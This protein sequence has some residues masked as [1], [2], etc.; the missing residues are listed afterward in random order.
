MHIPHNIGIASQIGKYTDAM[1]VSGHARWLYTSGT[2]GLDQDGNLPGDI[3]GQAGLA[4]RNIVCMQESSSKTIAD[5]VKV[6]HYLTQESDIAE[7]VKIRSN[8]LGDARPASILMIIPA[9]V[10]PDFLVE[11]EVIAAQHNS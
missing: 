7:Y 11:I 9:L 3:R 4:W 2:P 10:K 8:Y 5:I 6:T 1:E